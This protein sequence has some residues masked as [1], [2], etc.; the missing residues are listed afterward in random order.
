MKSFSRILRYILRYKTLVVLAVLCALIYAAMNG[1]SAYL[2]GPFIRTLFSDDVVVSVETAVQAEE[3][4]FLEQLKYT[5]QTRVDDLLGRGESHEILSRL[6]LWVIIVIVIKNIF[7]YLQGYIMAYVEQGV[8]RNLRED[9]YAAYHRLPL[10]YFQKRKTGDLISRVLND[11]HTVNT[12]LNSSLIN[13]IKEPINIVVLLVGMIVLS[14]KL[15]VFSFL[16]APPS[17]FIIS[18]ISKKLRRRTTHMQQRVST[19]TSVLEETITN[20]RIVKAFA[21]ERF[22]INKFGIANNDYF[23]ALLRLFRVRRLS[24]PVTEVLGVSMAVAVL[25]IGGRMVLD[26]K[27]LAPGDFIPFILLMFLLMQ[28]AKRLSEVNVKMQV[29]I[30]ASGR[31]FEIIDHPRDIIDSSN[32]R[33]IKSAKEGIRFRNVW[34]EYEVGV[35]V[36]KDIDLDITVGENIAIVGPSGGGKSTLVDLLPRFFDPLS[37]SVEID[38][39][40]IRDY[41]LNDLRSLF[42][43]VTQDTML[44]HDTIQANIAYGRPDIPVEHIITAAKNAYAH[45]FIM[46]FEDGYDTIIGDRGTKLSGGQKQRLVIAR[47]ILK[48]PPILIFD[49]A[50]SALDSESEAEVQAAIEKLM[51]GRTSFIIAHRLSTIQKATRIVVLDNGCIVQKGTHDQLYREGGI[52]RRLYDFQFAN[53]T[54]K[55]QQLL[56]NTVIPDK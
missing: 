52:Y 16:I 18:K 37:G 44:F 5:L 1:F 48:N 17:L 2:I 7:S 38:G 43:I 42:G 13:L 23:R 45:D 34:Y 27:S 46:K 33:P 28:S 50:T 19:I 20:I 9:V 47:A 54:T 12:N 26:Q 40:D 25:W 14:W 35:P 29:G 30:A 53:G 22:E 31:V 36:L 15:T 11:C 4:S 51:H 6:C 21:M 32:P 41:K 49:E 10:R 39:Y 24:S 55:N 8:V 56:G 3:M